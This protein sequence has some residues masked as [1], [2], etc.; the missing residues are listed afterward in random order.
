VHFVEGHPGAARLSVLIERGAIAEG[1]VAGDCEAGKVSLRGSERVL[2]V[3]GETRA[4]ERE[5]L[6]GLIGALGADEAAVADPYVHVQVGL[7]E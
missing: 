4:G 7:K 1:S 6:A 5:G 2:Q 3:R